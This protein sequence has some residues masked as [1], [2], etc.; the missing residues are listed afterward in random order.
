MSNSSDVCGAA[1]KCFDCSNTPVR[2]TGLIIQHT[3]VWA[4]TSEM[5]RISLVFFLFFFV[6]V[7]RQRVQTSDDTA[8]REYVRRQ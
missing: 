1:F 2:R 4:R 3:V 8:V 7:K 5:L 6:F